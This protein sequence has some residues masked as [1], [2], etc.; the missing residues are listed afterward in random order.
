MPIKDS[1]K[2]TALDKLLSLAEDIDPGLGAGLLYIAALV[3]DHPQHS[4][5]LL[6]RANSLA[7]KA[8]Q[9]TAKGD[10]TR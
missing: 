10:E 3:T 2:A 5:I 1:T 6:N 9:Y 7:N 4:R 8:R